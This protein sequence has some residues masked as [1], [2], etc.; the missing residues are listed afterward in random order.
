MNEILNK[1]LP[2]F[3]K[4]YVIIIF[5][6]GVLLL[7]ISSVTDK[8]KNNVQSFNDNLY[9]SELEQKISKTSSMIDGAGECTAIINISATT[10]SVFANDNKSLKQQIMPVISGVMIICE[11]G[12]D[13]SVKNSI[14][15][16]VSTLLGIGSNKVCVIAKAK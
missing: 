10:E 15:S 7:I 11:G 6:F 16:A 8:Q 14:I 3:K 9:I 1:I 2:Y 12:N 5:L 13:I 4:Y